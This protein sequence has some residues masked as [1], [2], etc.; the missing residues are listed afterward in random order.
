MLG[1]I[2]NKELSPFYFKSAV[3]VIYVFDLTNEESLHN[4]ALWKERVEEDNNEN[5]KSILIGN[6]LDLKQLREV[7]PEAAYEFQSKHSIDL[8]WEVSAREAQG[9]VQEA[10][11]QFLGHIEQ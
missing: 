4:L 2:K 9:G 3:G 7:S 10:L 6:K 1:D 11:T 8:Y 5:K